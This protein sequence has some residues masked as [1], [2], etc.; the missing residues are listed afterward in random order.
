MISFPDVKSLL[1]PDR[2]T[3]SNG[4]TVLLF[5]TES[6][7]LVKLDLIFDAGYS[8]QSQKLCARAVSKLMTVAT[9]CMDSRR[10]AEYL[11]YRGVLTDSSLGLCKNILS[12]YTHRRYLD[13]V[14]AVV[15][16]M[17]HQPA[18]NESDFEV[19]RAAK[20]QE[21]LAA[22][23]RSSAQARRIWYHA[24]FGP[25]HPLGQYAT[26]EELDRLELNSVADFHSG[27]YNNCQVIASGNVNDIIFTFVSKEASKTQ[28]AVG[29]PKA[30]AIQQPVV[31]S[32]DGA[33]Q[34]SFR[35]GR[36]LPENDGRLLILTSLLG[37]YFGSRLMS[38]LR[39]DKGFTYGISAHMQEYGDGTTVF[40]ILSDV[41]AGTAQ[42]AVD[43]V[44]SELRRLGEEPVSQEE[45]DVVRNV[46]AGDAMRALDGVFERA[47]RQCDI[48]E[49]GHSWLMDPDFGKILHEVTPDQLCDLARRYLNPEDMT[50]ALAGVI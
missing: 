33:Q 16:D 23:K 9:R 38:N 14:L 37:G 26:V 27:H 13:E 7:E 21:M 47:E 36:I 6:T 46:L 49:N 4:G 17:I 25:D 30:T 42:V 39:E 5:P 1:Q 11:D 18:F 45:L 29:Q 22:L 48:I 19:W 41:A 20:R 2:C 44:M 3:L 34:T 32:I 40:Y 8:L 31:F 50:V 28:Y 12:V 15:D 35:I 24:L 43:E 10:L